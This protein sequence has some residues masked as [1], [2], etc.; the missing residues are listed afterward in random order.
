MKVPFQVP[1][2]AKPGDT[3]EFDVPGVVAEAD[4][5]PKT[6][7]EQIV[8]DRLAQFAKGHVKVSGLDE[9]GKLA[10]AKQLGIKVAEVDE[11]GKPSGNIGKQL[12]AAQAEWRTRELTPALETAKRY[13]GEVQSLRQAKLTDA[14]IA[15]AAKAGVL[16]P[17]LSG[18]RPP[19]AALV[20]TDSFAFDE[21]TRQW[22]VKSADGF[23]ISSQPTA[24]QPWRT[25][26]EHVV[27]WTK[28]P[29]N[30]PF[31]GVVTQGGSNLGGGSAGASTEGVITLTAEQG[32]DF[33]TYQAALKQ[34]GGDNSRVKVAA[35]KY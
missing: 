34:V 21:K 30:K 23:A 28:K 4:V 27:E 3:I 5:M 20:G 1:A 2:T 7:V 29:E 33:G 10:L 6:V 25:V 15:A 12:E 14:I 31:V 17:L 8:Q 32:S 11:D 26:D 35:R 13:E 24:N 16:P 9:A 22:F 19:I 18:E